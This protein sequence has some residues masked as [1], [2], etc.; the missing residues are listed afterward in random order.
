[1]KNIIVP[2]IAFF[3][4]LP[5]ITLMANLVC[6]AFVGQGFLPEG[7]DTMNAA[8]GI[9]GW[10]SAAGAVAILGIGLGV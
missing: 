9:V 2:V 8:R 4:A 3:V 5:F 7:N 6:F 10:A 1:M